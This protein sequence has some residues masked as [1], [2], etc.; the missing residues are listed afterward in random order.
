M[1]TLLKQSRGFQANEA[2]DI[3][4]C[5]WQNESSSDAMLQCEMFRGFF[6]QA[7]KPRC[8]TLHHYLKAV[9]NTG[10]VERVLD[11]HAQVMAIA[12]LQ[13]HMKCVIWDMA[14]VISKLK[15]LAL[16]LPHH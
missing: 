14:F 7:S 15:C 2:S 1:L 6:I 5:F 8:R 12:N 4:T 9:G 3:I 10:V 13:V 11:G 16:L